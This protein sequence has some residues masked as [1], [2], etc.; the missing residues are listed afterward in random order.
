MSD[1]V[2]IGPAA[3]ESPL[4]ARLRAAVA[5]QIAAGRDPSDPA[6]GWYVSPEVAWEEVLATDLSPFGE[7]LAW[8]R[9]RLGLDALSGDVLAL[10]AAPELDPRFGRVYGFLLDDAARRFPTPGLVSSVLSRPG[11][12][13]DDVLERLDVR[14]PLR[15]FGC[16]RLVEHDGACPLV[17]RSIRLQPALTSFLLGVSLEEQ[18]AAGSLNKVELPAMPLGREEV[19]ERIAAHLEPASRGPLVV[20]GPDAAELIATA[21][22]RPLVLI[23]VRAIAQHGAIEHAALVAA[24]EGREVVLEHAE[25]LDE[26]DEVLLRR[27]AEESQRRVLMCATGTQLP[28]W[29]ADLEAALVETRLPVVG[30]RRQAWAAVAGPATTDAVAAKF[31]LSTAQIVRAHRAAL[32]EAAARGH[33]DPGPEELDEGARQ[34]SRAG[35]DQGAG[36]RHARPTF[37][38]SDL[39]LPERQFA[40]LRSISAYVRHRDQVLTDWGYDQTVGTRRGL[41]VLFAGESGTGKTMAAGVLADDLGLEL[42]TVDLSTTVSKY[43]GETEQ[44]LERVFRAVEGSNAIL[45]FDEA[46]ALFGRRSEVSDAQD[47][48]A[49]LEVAYLLQ[50]LETNPGAAI[51][52]T[53]LK[54]NI[55][56]AF[57]RRLDF[58]IDF[59]FPEVAARLRI[60]RNAIP[61]QAPLADDV[62]FEFL[63]DRFKL[64][65]GSIRNCSVAAA[66]EAV[67]AGKPIGMAHLVRAVAAEYGKLGRLAVEADFG[68]FQAML[69]D[70]DARPEAIEAPA[71]EPAPEPLPAP[72]P[73][74]RVRSRIQE[75]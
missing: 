49:N 24:L 30:E 60:W 3:A 25:R 56:E 19:V 63:A 38:W 65:G 32:R 13:P 71:E 36:A 7:R 16:L 52:A 59:P 45:F 1:P 43:I 27:L 39:V 51:L 46:D 47:R 28:S 37:Q 48:Y 73:V 34:A 12:S 29:L 53:N 11:T 8:A 10:S 6:G 40:Q 54:Q 42:V 61:P 17:D 50:R 18:A 66:F 74:R 64:S 57:L 68:R 62:D 31:R 55:D 20:A 67:A 58:V 21:L 70:P 5:A 15:R 75:L 9:K 35:L 4:E 69:R 41:K 2:S 26:A 33:A 14:A 72:A 44:N 23:D 22:G